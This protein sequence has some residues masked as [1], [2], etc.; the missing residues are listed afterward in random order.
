MTTTTKRLALSLSVLAAALSLA[1]AST[2]GVSDEPISAAAHERAAAEDRSTARAVADR[3]DNRA[4]RAVDLYPARPTSC[5]RSLP[6]S[7]SPYW[8]MTKNPTDRE[9]SL[10]AAYQTRARRHRQAAA[11]L[12]EAEAK[13][14]A[15][16]SLA[17]QDMSPLLRVRDI[18]AV[19]A[20]GGSDGRGPLGTP[21][22]A[23]IAFG[24]V[25]DLIAPVL[26]RIVSCHLARNA[27]LG[28]DQT[29]NAACPLNVKGAAASVR[30]AGDKVVVD[31]TSRDAAAALEIV[32][33]ARDLA[34]ASPVSRN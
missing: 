7:C 27:A 19:E 3:Y 22:G 11:A 15:L 32:K 26:Q 13:A 23:A 10:A 9:L 25:P 2:S 30:M 34:P 24:P 17:D 12:R 16:V 5:D 33:R 8:T 20:I 31:V 1:C 4:V 18:V 28:W 21:A 6:G 29:E 14:C